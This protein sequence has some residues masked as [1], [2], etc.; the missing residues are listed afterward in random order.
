MSRPYGLLRRYRGTHSRHQRESQRM[1][2]LDG[3][4]R[5]SQVGGREGERFI[6][7]GSQRDAITAYAHTHGH[8]IGQMF[9]ELDQSGARRDRPLL[10]AA[11]ARQERGEASVLCVAKLDRFGRSLVD[12]LAAIERVTAAGGSFVSVADDLDFSS[13][14]GRLVLRLMLSLGEWELDRVRA[15]WADAQHRAV[16]RGVFMQELAPL[17][18]RRTRSGRL[19]V[20]AA[21]APLARELFRRRLDGA[22]P[23]QLARWLTEQGIPTPRGGKGWCYSSVASIIGRRTYLGEV[24]HGPHCNPAAHTPLVDPA[25]WQAAQLAAARGPGPRRKEDALLRGLVRCSGCGRLMHTRSDEQQRLLYICPRQSSAGTC[26]RP[27]SV[28]DSVIEP[29]VEAV[30]WGQVTGSGRRHRAALGKAERAA[31]RATQQ[32]A[33]YRDHPT[34]LNTLGLERFAAGLAV[35]RTREERAL[36]AVAHERATAREAEPGAEQLRREWP[37]MDLT[38]KRRVIAAHLDCVFVLPGHQA[39]RLWAVPTGRAPADLPPAGARLMT[40]LRAF[41]PSAEQVRALPATGTLDWT[42]RKVSVALGPFMADRQEWPRF[43]EL[44]AAG[45][46]LAYANALRHQTVRSWCDHFAVKAPVAFRPM[47]LW[48]EERVEREL[49]AALAGWDRWP[50]MAQFAE[51]GLGELRKAVR[52]HGGAHR[53]AARLG[54]PMGRQQRQNRQ[55]WS[56]Q[57]IEQA[58]RQ[59]AAGQSHFPPCKQFEAAGLTGLYG[60][61]NRMGIR[62]ELADELGLTLPPGRH[63]RRPDKWTDERVAKELERFFAGRDRYP[64]QPEWNAA[65][66]A[67]LHQTLLRRVGGHDAIAQR[68]GL[69]RGRAPR[70]EVRG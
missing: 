4:I 44:Q 50:T 41:E 11:L 33:A 57:D 30:L 17:G 15:N 68:Y 51:M 38:A 45:L 55:R 26:P 69:P 20:D 43:Q 52:L 48:S 67:G 14:T 13:T 28:A 49:R 62:R 37:R 34:L 7:P 9:E 42:R 6:S 3:Y 2:I 23:T 29:Y 36:L 12:G 18:Y 32:L 65:G 46:A 59:L 56:G 47:P 40:S 60:T 10:L 64:T 61:I 39:D 53:W 21:T 16:A 54:L 70:A 27:V 8:T 63:Y 58:V 22:T 1:S 31:A 19:A 25:T 35:R 66:L 5:V 24:A